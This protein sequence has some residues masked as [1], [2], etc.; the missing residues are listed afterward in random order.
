MSD[1]LKGLT[2]GGWAGLFAW[3]FPSAIAVASFWVVVYGQLEHAPLH[4]FFSKLTTTESAGALLAVSAAIGFVLNA[5]ST[6]LYRLL[7]GY[8][9]PARLRKKGIAAQ[10]RIKTRVKSELAGDGWELGLQL[11]RLARF[12]VDDQEIAPTRLGNA[13]R[14]FETYGKSRFNLDSQTLWAELACVVPK[15]LQDE[16]NRSRAIVDFF[17]ALVYLSFGSG[18]L[19]IIVST[20]S[21]NKLAVC[22]YGLA[23]AASCFLWY[24]LAVTS[25][26]YWSSTVQA[27]VNIGRVKLAEQLGLQLPSTLQEEREMW[28]HLTLFVFYSDG[29]SGDRLDAYRKRMPDT[30]NGQRTAPLSVKPTPPDDRAE[31]QSNESD[32]DEDGS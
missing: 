26:T 7:E 31:A 8:A 3:I 16:L 1:L 2:G 6:P 15:S 29:A 17:V 24:R 18:V 25:S 19:S 21:C 32:D 5:V 12:P 20:G 9:W 10:R 4:A 28:G 27:L 11:E 13:L 14:S 30:V 22:T 23:S